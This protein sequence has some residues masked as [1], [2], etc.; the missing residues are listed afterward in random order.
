[1]KDNINKK[2]ILI[3]VIVAVFI[4]ATI[5]V[6]VIKDSIE[7]KNDLTLNENLNAEFD[8]EEKVSDFIKELKGT[9]VDDYKIETTSLG[10]K[11]IEFKYKNLHGW[12]KK[13]KFKINIIDT[14]AP[15]TYIESNFTVVKGYNKDLTEVVLS[16]DNCDPNPTRKIIG[17]YDFNKVGKYDLTFEISDASNNVT[18]KDFTLNVI[19]ASKSNNATQTVKKTKFTDVTSNYK[20]INTEFGIDVSEWQGDIDWD[21]VKE[22]GCDFTFIR[23]GY[24]NGF[25]GEN[26]ED[27]YF[28]QNIENAKK[29]GIDNIGIYFY[30][31]AKTTQ[32]AEEQA[33][34]VKE[35]LKDYEINL[36]VV[37]DW[38]SWSSFNKCKLSFFDINNIAKTFNKV[39]ED[40]GYQTMLYSSK[41]YL[42]KIWYADRF[43]NI[44]L[45]Q[46][47]SKVTYKEKYQYWQM[48]NTGKID[49]INGDVDIDIKY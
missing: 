27:K 36:P 31:Y 15:V 13:K 2:R 41:T 16:G 46:Y 9:I 21:K 10:E 38:E 25:D 40:N 32:E 29:S 39:L 30:S 42:E 12:K 24:Q 4:I 44:W 48:S 11:E 45:A 18:R 23:V 6:N 37:F 17:D 34:W 47:N 1:M 33:N 43:E 49:G 26:K 28:K 8:T 14:V 7:Y 5:I 19:E 22:S 35:E 3:A 20:K